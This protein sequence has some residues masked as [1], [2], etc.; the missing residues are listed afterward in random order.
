MVRSKI[1]FPPLG[2][3]VSFS[4]SFSALFT[5]SD[6]PGTELSSPLLGEFPVLSGFSFN[7]SVGV[8][9]VFWLTRLVAVLGLL[10]SLRCSSFA[11]R[12]LTSFSSSSIGASRLVVVLGLT[13]SVS[14]RRLDNQNRLP[15][16]G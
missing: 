11:A 10:I 4:F 3:D 14:A 1:I 8:P 16:R 12:S 13:A 6:V 7:E 9:P 5:L 2:L 15:M